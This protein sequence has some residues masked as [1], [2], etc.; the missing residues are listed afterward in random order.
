ME[1]KGKDWRELCAAAAEEPDSE[2]LA[3]LVNQIL[4]VFDEHD[5]DVALSSRSEQ[6]C[7]KIPQQPATSNALTNCAAAA[8]NF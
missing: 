6:W 3:S 5:Q 4:E 8:R 1:S 7:G 2:K